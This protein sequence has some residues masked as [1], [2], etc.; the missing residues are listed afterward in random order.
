VKNQQSREYNYREVGCVVVLLL[1]GGENSK[2]RYKIC[3]RVVVCG[4]NSN[5]EN[6][7]KTK[8][9]KSIAS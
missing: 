9:G 4:A 6:R 2:N 8:K 5:L 1:G 7:Y 3:S